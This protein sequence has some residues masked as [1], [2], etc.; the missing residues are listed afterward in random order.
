MQ[1]ISVLLTIIGILPIVYY[2]EIY[3]KT[4]GK[5]IESK[6]IFDNDL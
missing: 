3:I 2:V 4:V 1:Y 6:E 5:A